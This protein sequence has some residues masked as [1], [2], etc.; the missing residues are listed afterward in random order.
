MVLILLI[1]EWKLQK[2]SKKKSKNSDK[3]I[4]IYIRKIQ[5]FLNFSKIFLI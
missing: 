4:N 2:K 5:N 3:F 1:D